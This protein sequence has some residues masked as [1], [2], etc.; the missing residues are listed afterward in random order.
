MGSGIGRSFKEMKG[1]RLGTAVWL[2]IMRPSV[3][4]SGGE[5]DRLARSCDE[6][7]EGA[8]EGRK[9]GLGF[10]GS[11]DVT[12]IGIWASTGGVGTCGAG[13]TVAG[14]SA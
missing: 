3:G 4:D 14:L 12:R 5:G 10:G 8:D 1:G 2:S 13:F 6:G 7:R 11:R 9:P